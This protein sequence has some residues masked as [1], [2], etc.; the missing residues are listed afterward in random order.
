MRNK[1]LPIILLLL[2]L[3]LWKGGMRFMANGV[4]LLMILA[5]LGLA[6]VLVWRLIRKQFASGRRG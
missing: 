1:A 5:A 4:A 2:L 3:L 6:A